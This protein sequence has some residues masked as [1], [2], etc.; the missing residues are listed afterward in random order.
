MWIASNTK[1]I[2][3]NNKKIEFLII[4][5]ILNIRVNEF[6]SREMFQSKYF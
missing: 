6:Q 5:I 3:R 1:D 4:P 2:Y